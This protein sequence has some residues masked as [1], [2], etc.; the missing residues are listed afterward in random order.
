LLEEL[1]GFAIEP[2]LLRTTTDLIE[3]LAN[4]CVL[5]DKRERVASANQA[6][7]DLFGLAPAQLVGL[8][9]FAVA[10][11]LFDRPQIRA[12]S[13]GGGAWH[14]V[15]DLELDF[16]IPVLGRR[17]V[18]LTTVRI[19]ADW[20]D[21][22]VT[23]LAFQDNTRR[24]LLAEERAALA[25]AIDQAANLIAVTDAKGALAYANPAFAH[26]VGVPAT[27]LVG[28]DATQV[29]SKHLAPLRSDDVACFLCADGWSGPCTAV[30]SGGTTHLVDV[31][32]APVLGPRGKVNGHVIVGL[33]VT[34][35]RRVEEELRREVADRAAVAR[36]LSSLRGAASLE[37]TAEELC[38]R[39]RD[40]PGLDAAAV[41]I[42]W[43][44]GKVV[45][46]AAVPS[47]PGLQPRTPMPAAIGRYLRE[48][49]M[50]GPWVEPCRGAK[51]SIYSRSLA[52]LGLS[53][54][55]SL[56]IIGAEGQVGVLVVGTAKDGVAALL[57]RMPSL[58]EFGALAT[59]LLAD[60]LAAR[61]AE[62]ASQRELWDLIGARAFDP[63]FQPIVELS[64][65]SVVGYEALTRFHDQSDPA[66]RFTAAREVGLGRVL[67]QA[68]MQAALEEAA[69]LPDDAWLA[70]NVSAD[71][72]LHG[73]RLRRLTCGQTRP[74]VLEITEHEPVADPAAIRGAVIRLGDQLRTLR[75]A[76]DDAGAG[77]NGLRFILDL[78]PDLIKLDRA[79]ITDID[80]DPARQALVVGMRHFANQLG[81]QLVAEGVETEAALMTL[82]T[83]G[84]TYGQGHLLGRPQAATHWQHRATSPRERNGHGP[85]GHVI[86]RET[87]RA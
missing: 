47:G 7:G 70:L 48:R 4:P 3:R 76:V 78:A 39:I 71:F 28:A 36:T 27:Q 45:P 60:P 15:Q 72:A 29:L 20:F 40:H 23:L 25:T 10:D 22:G 69:V 81:A 49:S 50:A 8:P 79:L 16:S 14:E 75:I 46:V 55:A 61:Q 5:V 83:L 74:L 87:D 31:V 38:A 73:T 18:S 53:A 44:R 35:E 33:D 82:N 51:A 43:G 26:L 41:L 59:A 32:T 54:V 80:K 9:V 57:R 66:E 63:V 65:G 6:L 58:I 62:A 19:Q 68:T 2:I 17:V 84:V 85:G 52:S 56:P 13:G 11:G 12:L 77:F 64:S 21:V 37:A 24:A 30:G 67:E 1:S 34:R 42:T 86:R